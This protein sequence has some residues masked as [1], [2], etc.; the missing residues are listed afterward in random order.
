[1]TVGSKW[2]IYI[3]S[4][5]AYGNRGAGDTIGPGATLVF[6]VEL[7]GIQHSNK[8]VNLK[9]ALKRKVYCSFNETNMPNIYYF[10]WV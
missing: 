2:K 3:P 7:L 1:M 10:R 5:L 9:L 8:K 6:T 4:D